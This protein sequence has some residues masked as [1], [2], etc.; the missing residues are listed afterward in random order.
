M[1]LQSFSEPNNFLIAIKVLYKYL[2]VPTNYLA[3]EPTS[4]KEILKVTY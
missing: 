2:K 3:D 1:N 4:A